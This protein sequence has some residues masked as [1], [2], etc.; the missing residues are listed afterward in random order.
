MNDKD[1]CLDDAESVSFLFRFSL[2]L[3]LGS[4]VFDTNFNGVVAFKGP[5]F[6]VDLSSVKSEVSNLSVLYLNTVSF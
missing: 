3:Y 4:G 2:L 6:F 1:L 5:I